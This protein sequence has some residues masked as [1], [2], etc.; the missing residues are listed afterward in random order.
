M[1]TSLVTTDGAR[2]SSGKG[3]VRAGSPLA[4]PAKT[5]AVS[6]ILPQ[7]DQ[8]KGPPIELGR[9]ERTRSD[10]GAQQQF[11]I[12]VGIPNTG[13]VNALSTLNL[14]GERSAHL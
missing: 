1:C 13:Q 2:I 5:V 3:P 12:M 6:S 8:Y 10:S 4:F 7:M 9:M 14:R 11:G